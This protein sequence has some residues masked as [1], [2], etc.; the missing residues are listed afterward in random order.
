MMQLLLTFLQVNPIF[1]DSIHAFGEHMEPV[2]ASLCQFQFDTEISGGLEIKKLRRSGSQLRHTY[3]LRSP[4]KDKDATHPWSIRQT[5]VYH[6][7]DLRT[8]RALWISIKGNNV[9][10][11]SVKKDTSGYQGQNESVDQPFLFTLK[12]HL[13][14]LRWCQESWRWFVR[15]LENE[16]RGALIRA[17]TTPV[18]REPYFGDSGSRYDD[19]RTGKF[20]STQR[21][22]MQPST[23]MSGN[24][25]GFHS[26]LKK[27]SV[28]WIRIRKY[29]HNPNQHTS[30]TTNTQV[31]RQHWRTD[32][33]KHWPGPGRILES[34][35]FE[36]LQQLNIIGERIQE[37][38]LVIKLDVKS[39]LELK[40][41]YKNLT[42]RD[43]L[44]PECFKHLPPF[45]EKV[46]SIVNY[47][48]TRR[49]QLESLTQRLE[50]GKRLVSE[51][52]NQTY[53]CTRLVRSLEYY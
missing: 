52:L 20:A 4:E 48:E 14:Y 40:M 2:D 28:P 25:A 53:L 42:E 45:L 6:A 24:S 23:W 37:A 31:S 5:A 13:V 3:L 46:Q 49:I 19:S 18:G 12:T 35:N 39:L 15:D 9:L 32:N 1:L 44:P 8:G 16:V 47:M 34:F 11:D 30:V 50:E 51:Y 29:E 26:T 7:F 22:L 17:R 38:A 36:D 27:T 33:A 10:Q 43:E 41:Y 21:K